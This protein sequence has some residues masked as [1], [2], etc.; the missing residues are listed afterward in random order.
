MH[1]RA[2][3]AS[4]LTIALVAVLAAAC[5]G[6]GSVAPA[7]GPLVTVE[8]RGGECPA[9]A[10][11]M[12]AILERNGRVH[13]AAK[14]PNEL[15]V[16]PPAQLAGLAAAIAST[17]FTALRS[18]PFTGE[19]PTAFDGQ[20]IVFEFGAPGGVERISTCE[21]QVD[22]G[23]PVFVAVSAALGPFIPLPTT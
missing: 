22:F 18:R 5:A 4:F 20:E 7:Q 8:I 19:C 13:L 23:L 12:T 9:G 6:P 17:D 3:L 11:G 21:V 16:V 14:P 15:G 10:C 2:R 1:A